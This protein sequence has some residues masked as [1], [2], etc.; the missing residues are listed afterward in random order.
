MKWKEIKD[1]YPKAFDAWET[2]DINKIH[3]HDWCLRCA[4]YDF[5][6]EQSIYVSISHN[7]VA[8]KFH[9]DIST[10][11]MSDDITSRSI[12]TRAEAEKAAFNKAFEVLEKTLKP[13]T[14]D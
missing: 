2:D 13:L 9:Y 4:L 14:K 7:E 3:P 12:Y 11:P 1:K 6:D 10:K 5:F 8:R